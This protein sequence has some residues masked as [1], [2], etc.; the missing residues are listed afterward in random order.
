MLFVGVYVSS[1]QPGNFTSSDS[2]GVNPPR[3]VVLCDQFMQFGSTRLGAKGCM[4]QGLQHFH[5]TE[6]LR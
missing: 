5:D 3:F 6:I 2:E 4:G 1:F